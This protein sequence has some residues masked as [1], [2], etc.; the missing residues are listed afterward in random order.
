MPLD[1]EIR[2][3]FIDTVR[4]LPSRPAMTILI[5]I[6]NVAVFAWMVAS[7][8]D[9]LAPDGNTLISWGADFGPRTMNGEWWR[10]GTCLFLHFGIVHLGMNMLVLWGLGRLT[11]RLVGS[12]GFAIAY[13]I[14]GI[15]GS[16]V[17]LT[18]NPQGISAGA[19]GAVFGVAGILLGFVLLR[20]D[21]I[22]AQVRNQLLLSMAKFLLLNSVI[23][24]SVARVD[25]A[26]HTGGFLAGVICGLIL[27]QPISLTMRVRRK[28]R[29][30]SLLITAAAL[31]PI[32][33]MALPPAPTDIESELQRLGSVE[34]D[35]CE[36]VNTI[37]QQASD[38]A[39]NEQEYAKQLREQVLPT[40]SDY[41]NDVEGLS[42]LDG[43]NQEYFS[44]IL[45]YIELRGQ[46][47]Q[48][49]AEGLQEQDRNKL[50]R[51]GNLTE[52]ANN[53]F[54]SN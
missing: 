32:G 27:S 5:T 18:W 13:L 37:Q 50:K 7:G 15:A 6:A 16:I 48:L 45:G 52:E 31:V 47:W 10:M 1:E 21:T 29:N 43:A 42:K 38:G 8:V 3:H 11:E 19:S 4:S 2:Q 44:Q 17:S 34:R 28:F 36:L 9:Y 26:A 22:P 40:W 14:S 54:S 20:R 49:L 35:V 33:I 30:L 25:M 51:S 39:I 12:V 24:F 46:S 23:G 41:R 53:W